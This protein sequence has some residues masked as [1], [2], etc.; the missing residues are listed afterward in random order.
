MSSFGFG[1]LGKLSGL[2]KNAG[3]IQDMMKE[4]QEALAQKEVDGAS[5]GDLVK[6][7]MNGRYYVSSIE[8]SDEAMTEGVEVVFEL[9]MAAINDATEKVEALTK[10]SMMN[11][12]NI[13]SPDD[14]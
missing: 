3:K 12:A 10:E 7:K 13:F 4:S 1:D 5:G 11:V 14:L 2:L 6:V 9:V 8:I